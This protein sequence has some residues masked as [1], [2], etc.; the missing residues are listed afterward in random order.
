MSIDFEF[1]TDAFPDR[2]ED[3]REHYNEIAGR[4]LLQAISD[5]MMARG[6]EM[7][8]I[9]P[10]DWGWAVFAHRGPD[11]YFLGAIS[12]THPDDPPD[13]VSPVAHRAF[14][15]ADD[16]VSLRGLLPFG[17]KRHRSP[18]GAAEAALFREV[19]AALP[20]VSGLVR[21]ET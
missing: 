14:L 4:A 2:P 12:Y 15:A 16:P 18:E 9:F 7:E 1:A 6:F 20:G 17:R 13:A 21:D 19:L 3:V 11:R 5:R 8:D 10:E